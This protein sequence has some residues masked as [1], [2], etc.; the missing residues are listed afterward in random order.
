MKEDSMVKRFQVFFL[1]T[2]S[3]KLSLRVTILTSLQKFFFDNVLGELQLPVTFPAT[4]EKLSTSYFWHLSSAVEFLQRS[5]SS[6]PLLFDHFMSISNCLSLLSCVNSSSV[7]M[8]LV[9]LI[10]FVPLLSNSLILFRYS[11]LHFS[12]YTK[13]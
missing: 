6:L 8:C 12:I 5:Y 3:S 2:C 1:A 10:L 9:Y 11:Q 13:I 7:D 4:A